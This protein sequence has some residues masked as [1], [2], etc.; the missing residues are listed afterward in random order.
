MSSKSQRQ[1]MTNSS[2]I[3]LQGIATTV[4]LTP[5]SVEVGLQI[6][7]FLEPNF[8]METMTAM[9]DRMSL[10]AEVGAHCYLY[11]F[12]VRPSYQLK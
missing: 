10:F 1:N 8:V 6:G 11:V 5:C 4:L 2:N 3:S 12:L 7:A 9:M